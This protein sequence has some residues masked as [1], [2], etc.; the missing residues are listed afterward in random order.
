MTESTTGGELQSFSD[1]FN[2]HG[3]RVAENLR[4]LDSVVLNCDYKQRP[5]QL[6]TAVLDTEGRDQR[7]LMTMD[8]FTFLAQF[9]KLSGKQF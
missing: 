5:V 4:A 6:M 3:Q 7:L 8:Y 9:E 2:S 1:C